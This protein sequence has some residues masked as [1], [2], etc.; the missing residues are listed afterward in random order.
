M[1]VLIETPQYSFRK[2]RRVGDGF[3][4]DLES[5]LPTLFNYGI[6]K[7]ETAA[8]GLPRDVVV[9]GDSL[10]QGEWVEVEK[11]GVVEFM[12]DSVVDDKIIASM[13][14]EFSRWQEVKIKV[15][16]HVYS[17]FKKLRVL[18]MEDRW[19]DTVFKGFTRVR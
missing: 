5:P 6:L 3:E 12:D 8:D 7:G 17:W 11:V 10:K 13:N 16:F 1:E 19:P 15:F 2:Y 9:L 4:V 14:G 18:A